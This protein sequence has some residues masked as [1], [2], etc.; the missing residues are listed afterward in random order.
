[1]FPRRKGRQ[2]GLTYIELIT[3]LALISLLTLVAL[4]YV[5]HRYRR[6]Q[7]KELRR[8]LTEMRAAIDRYHEYAV[9]G[10]IEPWDL[11][12]MNYPEDLEMLV[13]GVEVRP[14]ADQ[15]PIVIKFLRK[16]PIDPIT[17]EAEWSCRAY[18]DE[19]DDRESSCDTLYDVFS[20]SN[21]Q[22]LDGTYYRD[23]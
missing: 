4:P 8:A 19:P 17:G 10:Q 16:I 13:E 20:T 7:E 21:E 23:W 18:D 12:W 11:E 5:H 6:L 3:V 1:M 15:E 22:A 14:S 2:A 9:L